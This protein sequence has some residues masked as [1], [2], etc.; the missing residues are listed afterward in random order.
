MDNTQR[1]GGTAGIITAAC[2]LLLFI[3]FVS[4]G[5]DPQTAQ[6]PAKALPLVAQRGGVFAGIGVLGLL[7]A[8]FGLVFTIGLFARLRGGAPTRAAALLGLA[9]VG[10]TVHAIGATVLWQG[11]QFLVGVAAK[12]QTA[13][14]NAWIAVTAIVQ[15]LNAMANGFTGASILLAGWAIL[16]THAM[17][18]TIGWIA[19]LAGIVEMLQTFSAAAPLVG[20]GFLLTIV[21][22]AWGGST[23]RRPAV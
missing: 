12:D 8:G 5:L 13:A 2:L 15:G 21:W 10:L 3:L 20:L 17:G 18:T 1:N 22:L 19:V 11:G 9:F 6:D 23:L 16:D 4:S 7:A 14:A